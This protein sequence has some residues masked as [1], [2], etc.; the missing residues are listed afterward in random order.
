MSEVAKLLRFQGQAHNEFKI[1]PVAI[2]DSAVQFTSQLTSGYS[3][4]GCYAYNNSDSSSGEIYWGD[5]GVSNI[6][7]FPI[8][9]GAVV[10]IPIIVD[11]DVYFIG[12]S[13]E[14]GDL[15]VLELA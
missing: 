11:L 1:T 14:L 8:P 6:S 7:G 10:E 15:R 3:R 4:I 5:S 13:G 9:R 2:N 12:S